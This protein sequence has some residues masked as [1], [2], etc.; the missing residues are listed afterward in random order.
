VVSRP[1][2]FAYSEW[3]GVFFSRKVYRVPYDFP[4]VAFSST[5][6]FCTSSLR[7]EFPFVIGTPFPSRSRRS[8]QRRSTSYRSAFL[9]NTFRLPFLSDLPAGPAPLCRAFSQCGGPFFFPSDHFQSLR[10]CRA[11]RRFAS[12]MPLPVHSRGTRNLLFFPHRAKIAK[13]VSQF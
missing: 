1:F 12:G 5:P 3:L 11:R 7:E 10:Y 6:F 13:T 2:F 9:L 4:G 8:S